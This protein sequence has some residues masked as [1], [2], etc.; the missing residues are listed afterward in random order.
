MASVVNRPNGRREIQ[1]T[2]ANGK[3]QTIR[4]GKMPKRDAEG[5]KTRVE[6]LLTAKISKQPIEG[7]TAKW[8]AS[9]DDT[10]SKRLASAG[11]VQHR[12]SATLADFLESYIN[13]R[14]D[15]KPS[16]MKKYKTTKDYLVNFYGP[17]RILRD[18]QPGDVDEWRRDLRSIR[19]ENTVRK[20][21]AVAKVFFNAAVRK[22]LI[23]KNPFEGQVATIQA[24]P[25]RFHFISM[26]DSDK[27][28][29][30]C[31]DVEWRLI[32]A[33]SRFGG[34]RCPSEHLA[35]TWDCVDWENSRLR[36]PSPKTEHLAGK[37]VR[38]IPIFPEL[39]PHLE[40]VFDLAD[41][42]S[43][44]VITRY[45]DSNSNLRTQLKRIIVRAGL[46][47]WPRLFHNLRSTRQTEL[48]ETRPAHVV[49]EWIGNTE[50]VAAKHYLQITDE[51]YQDAI[52]NPTQNPTQSVHDSD[53]SAKPP[54][55]DKQETSGKSMI[56]NLGQPLYM[57]SV[58]REGLEPPTKGL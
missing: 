7:N 45:R 40:A 24:N 52:N 46:E 55:P 44:H 4:L 1:Y 11:L 16:T 37:A 48:T 28:L 26:S 25:D 2:D 6:H 41:A 38:F 20:Y 30:A 15:V 56:V 18:I 13:G 39:R 5:I 29:A 58:V 10:L 17:S 54:R 21:I 19:Q 51:H 34:L 42:G 57:H 36:V 23:E 31:P 50:D 3:R 53:D 9:L 49:C 35:L 12:E 27:I 43:V 47:P 8:V 32:F 33:L 14:T 22:G